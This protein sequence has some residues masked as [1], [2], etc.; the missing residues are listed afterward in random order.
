MTI[1]ADAGAEA[2]ADF[3]AI[4][5]P[6][7]TVR[8]VKLALQVP[9]QIAS[10]AMTSFMGEF[11]RLAEAEGINPENMDLDP[12]AFDG[13]AQAI[14]DGAVSHAA[15]IL[16]QDSARVLSAEQ[17]EEGRRLNAYEDT[18]WAAVIAVSVVAATED[19]YPA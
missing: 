19:G 15:T 12:E 10:L 16:E 11:R 7:R 18:V 17:I 6:E 2:L 4:L 8:C 3:M 14:I 9:A 13:K 1:N 5:G